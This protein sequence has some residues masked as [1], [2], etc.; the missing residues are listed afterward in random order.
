MILQA[1]QE[2]ASPRSWPS[3]RAQH[4]G[5]ASVGRRKSRRMRR[6]ALPAPAFRLL[7]PAEHLA[8]L[9]YRI[10]VSPHPQPDARSAAPIPLV[11]RMREWRTCMRNSMRRSRSW[12]LGPASRPAGT[13]IHRSITTGLW[14]TS[15]AK[16]RNRYQLAGTAST[17][18]P[19]SL[20]SSGP[21]PPF[22]GQPSRSKAARRSGTQPRWWCGRDVDIRVLSG[23]SRR[24]RRMAARSGAHLVKRTHREPHWDAASA[25]CSCARS[26]RERT[27]NPREAYP[28]RYRESDR[29][30]RDIHQNGAVARVSRSIWREQ[31]RT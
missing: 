19:G 18:V 8:G 14:D 9:S 26:A 17:G 25:G 22:A 28:L 10:R 13:S 21:P 2:G 23:R 5:P 4:P 1:G 6:T 31:A 3:R 20:S 11:P 24:L 30:D 15:V 12:R 29:G 16:E 27:A 7:D